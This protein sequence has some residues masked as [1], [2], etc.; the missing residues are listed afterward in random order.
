MNNNSFLLK[1][2]IIDNGTI[3]GEIKNNFGFLTK[4]YKYNI[5]NDI[6][7]YDLKSNILFGFR[8]SSINGNFEIINIIKKKRQ[9][10][11]IEENITK[12]SD[13]LWFPVKN[14]KKFFC[15]ANEDYILNENDIIKFGKIMYEV[16]KKKIIKLKN[17]NEDINNY[18]ISNINNKAGPIFNIDINEDQYIIS[19]ENYKCRKCK[20]TELSEENPLICLCKCGNYIHFNCLKKILN[21]KLERTKENKSVKI[22]N[23]TNFKCDK[24]SFIFPLKF[25]IPKI[26]KIYELF[27]FD[28]LEE[29]CDYIVLEQL[30]SFENNNKENIKKIIFIRLTKEEIKIGK[31]ESNDIIINDDECISRNHSILKYYK[32]DGKLFLENKS[33]RNNTFILI[34]DNIKMNEKKVNFKEENFYISTWIEKDIKGKMNFIFEILNNF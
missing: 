10:K 15:Q 9:I 22:Y 19:D 4:S 16:I 2:K 1:L 30:N 28:F 6:N 5:I 32:E 27:D 34:K 17:Q 11:K 8:K 26:N 20:K 3:T 7:D 12:L 31:N 23:Y 25:R 29:K 24:C 18:N 14:E 33:E 21:S 13:K